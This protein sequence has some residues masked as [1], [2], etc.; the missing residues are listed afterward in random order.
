MPTIARLTRP[1][2]TS[3]PYSTNWPAQR[4]PPGRKD[5]LMTNPASGTLDLESLKNKYA[6]EREKRVRVANRGEYTS[7]RGTPLA[8]KFD[9]DIWATSDGSREPVAREFDA[10]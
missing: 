9:V 6:E 10:V 5:V 8:G 3:P 1:R 2:P 7:I 4:E